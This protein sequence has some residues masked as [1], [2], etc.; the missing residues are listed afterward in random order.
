MTPA[1]DFFCCRCG[2]NYWQAQRFCTECGGD[3]LPSSGLRTRPR[4]DRSL[5][6]GGLVAVVIALGVMLWIALAGIDGPTTGGSGAVTSSAVGRSPAAAIAAGVSPS[7]VAAYIA[8]SVPAGL[9]LHSFPSYGIEFLLPQ[10]WGQAAADL[11]AD[12]A[13]DM[14]ELEDELRPDGVGLLCVYADNASEML[15]PVMTD[16]EASDD[17]DAADLEVKGRLIVGSLSGSPHGKVGLS[18]ETIAGKT[19]LISDQIS[20]PGVYLRAFIVFGGHR[21]LCF[22]PAAPDAAVCDAAVARL[23]SLVGYMRID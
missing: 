19:V 3:V 5:L 22:L 8:P 11:P 15:M 23:R 10:S 4:K 7:P 1:P 9:A 12:F 21:E 16:A 17:Y 13:Q 20:E 6:A 18:V 2:R 14:R